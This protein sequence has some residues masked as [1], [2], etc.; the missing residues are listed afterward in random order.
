VSPA[1]KDRCTPCDSVDRAEGG[2]PRFEF[3]VAVKRHGET[4]IAHQGAGAIEHRYLVSL[5]M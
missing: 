1:A 4:P 2:E 5:L 3:A